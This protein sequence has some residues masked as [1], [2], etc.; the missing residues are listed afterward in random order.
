MTPCHNQAGFLE[1]TIRSV[2]EQDYP[3]LEYLIVDDGSTDGSVDIIHR[4]A[5]RLA[6]W[7]MQPNAGASAALNRGFEHARGDYLG[8]LSS[9]DTLLP[10]AISRLVDVLEREPGAVLAYGDGLYTDEASETI[11]YAFS[12]EWDT[13]W[14]LRT[15]KNP[16]VQQAALWTRRGWEL[17]GPLDEDSGY[18]FDLEFYLRLSVHGRLQRIP[19]P[20]ATVRLHPATKSSNVLLKAQDAG[21]FADVVLMDPQLPVPLRPDARRGRAA[22]L[23]RSG[24]N[25]YVALDLP[26][27][28]RQLLRAFSAHPAVVSRRWA[29]LL[30]K[31]VLPTPVVRRLRARRVRSLG[32]A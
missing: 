6:W 13:R 12:R 7:T 29:V 3:A 17:A 5:E 31:S 2:L 18:F 28:R 25:Y 26:R 15:A 22:M 32:I 30:V 10:G 16:I 8:F 27:A 24:M 1:E 14:V 23:L 11:G 9:D 20:L 21:R 19:E 4:Y